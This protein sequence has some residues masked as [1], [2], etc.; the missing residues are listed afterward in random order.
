MLEDVEYIQTP[1][2]KPKLKHIYQ[3]YVVYI[4]KSGLREKLLQEL[5]KKGIETKIGT[6]ALHLEP[7]FKEV[8]KVG[9]LENSEKLYK[10]L[11]A[12]PMYHGLSYEDQKYV[13]DSISEILGELI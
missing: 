4:K 8:K 13:C 11:L 1:I 10:N 6:Y 9:S 3:T 12:L 2:V 5:L 7:S